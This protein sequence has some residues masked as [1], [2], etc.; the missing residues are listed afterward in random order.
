M[1]MLLGLS[2]LLLLLLLLVSTF[3]VGRAQTCAKCLSKFVILSG[4]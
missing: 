4:S 2:L 3:R 1:L